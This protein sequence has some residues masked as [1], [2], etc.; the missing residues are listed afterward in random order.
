MENTLFDENIHDYT[1]TYSNDLQDY[2]IN[3]DTLDKTK[4][5]KY[6]SYNGF[7]VGKLYR[8]NIIHEY[9][10]EV[11]EILRNPEINEMYYKYIIL[12]SNS[13]AKTRQPGY[14]RIFMRTSDL[15]LKSIPL[16]D[17]KD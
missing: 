11:L 16:E 9:T 8:Y 3:Y 14:K 13:D 10:Y 17:L 5:I 2:S 7:T 1:D 15:E 12:F 4:L 6:Y